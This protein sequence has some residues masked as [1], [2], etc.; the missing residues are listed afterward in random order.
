MRTVLLTVFAAILITVVSSADLFAQALAGCP[1]LES[2]QYPALLFIE[3]TPEQSNLCVATFEGG[4]LTTKVIA[5]ARYIE[6]TQLD[7]GIFLVSIKESARS[8]TVHAIDLNNGTSRQLPE[9][10]NISCL[11]S[12]PGRKVA[13]LM[14]PNMA[15]IRFVELD[16]ETF[17]TRSICELSRKGADEDCGQMMPACIR[18]SPDSSRIAYVCMCS[19]KAPLHRSRHSLKMMELS[20]MMSLDLVGDIYVELPAISSFSHGLP[21]FEWLSD[22]EILYQDMEPTPDSNESFSTKALHV[23]KTVNVRTKVV[24][25]LFREERTMALDGGRMVYDPASGS[26]VYNREWIVDLKGARLVP[27]NLPFTVMRDYKVRQTTVAWGADELYHGDENCLGT[28]ISASGRN[29][30]YAL[31]PLRETLV[32]RLYAKVDGIKEPLLVAEGSYAPTSAV[33]WVEGR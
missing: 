21:P 30:A 10:T 1:K 7:K 14:D 27:R 23:F 31:R 5:S 26:I 32:A 6:A 20:T 33:A 2:S 13:T 28:W 22:E 4:Q 19:D 15:R 18:K 16:L 25:E 9:S 29:F 3:G 12:E 24:T 11:R 17:A 8:G